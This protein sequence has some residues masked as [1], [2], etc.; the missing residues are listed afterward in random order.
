MKYCVM[1]VE[2]DY[3]IYYRIRDERNKVTRGKADRISNFSS[4]SATL[5]SL[6]SIH[7][8]PIFR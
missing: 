6:L 8:T 4:F 1:C 3:I 7:R 5:N 2:Q